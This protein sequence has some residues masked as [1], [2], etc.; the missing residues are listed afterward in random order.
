MIPNITPIIIVGEMMNWLGYPLN[1]MTTSFIPMALGIAV[2]DTIHLVSHSHVAHD[3]C[4]NYAEAV[5]RTFHTE[6]L[7]ITMSVVVISAAFIDFVFSDA[8]QMSSWGALTII[9]MVST[10]L[11]D[12]FLT[13]ILMDYLHIFEQEKIDINNTQNSN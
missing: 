3:R 7:A 12:L 2:D 10:L 4:G 9:D 6:E 5:S 11:A 13:P 8:T 1:T